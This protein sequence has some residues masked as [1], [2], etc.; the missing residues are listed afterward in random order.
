MLAFFFFI[1]L[2]VE[3]SQCL[4]IYIEPVAVACRCVNTGML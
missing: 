1:D 4:A 2:S 3:L